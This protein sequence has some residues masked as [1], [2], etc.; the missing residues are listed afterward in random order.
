MIIGVV[1]L[2]LYPSLLFCCLK[3][4]TDVQNDGIIHAKNLTLEDAE[5]QDLDND[6]QAEALRVNKILNNEAP[7]ETCSVS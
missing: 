1:N 2:I 7:K 3:K 5:A 4:R 6:V